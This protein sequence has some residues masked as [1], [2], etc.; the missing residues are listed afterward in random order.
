MNTDLTLLARRVR[1]LEA[2]LG[3]HLQVDPQSPP[4]AHLLA[5]LTHLQSQLRQIVP[6]EAVAAHRVLTM[7][8]HATTSDRHTL[9]NQI[10]TMQQ[11]I[12]TIRPHIAQLE[13]VAE[14]D[15]TP[16]AISTDDSNTL[17]SLIRRAAKAEAQQ[18]EEDSQVD[19]LLISFDAST[20]RI[21][22][23]ILTLVRQ[24]E[25]SSAAL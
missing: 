6:D 21:N 4:E 3:P 17:Q 1:R 7:L 2:L 15:I 18:T 13:Q 14:K 24:L 8:A 10:R 23:Y 9:L 25:L 20:A 12:Q 5:Q 11:R 19:E 22:S 16:P